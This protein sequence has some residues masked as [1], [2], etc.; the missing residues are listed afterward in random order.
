MSGIRSV[1][2]SCCSHIMSTPRYCHF[3]TCWRDLFC[4]TRWP[5]P[6]LGCPTPP[7]LLLG[8]CTTEWCIVGDGRRFEPCILGRAKPL[9]SAESSSR[10]GAPAEKAE[11]VM[12][13]LA[14]PPR[15]LGGLSRG[16][17]RAK[18]ANEGDE[19]PSRASGPRDPLDLPWH[20]EKTRDHT[21]AI[22]SASNT[23]TN[24]T[25]MAMVMTTMMIAVVLVS[26]S[27]SSSSWPR[28]SSSPARPRPP[29]SA[30]PR[31]QLG[32]Q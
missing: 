10:G 15:V 2:P 19:S 22:T 8:A 29:S 17:A 21:I 13:R 31:T 14:W 5:D 6:V 11:R 3:P 30:T 26:S 24:K 25:V 4:W 12:P 32:S 28:S 27:Q 16:D 7:A 1:V 18:R 23:N 20:Y 9:L